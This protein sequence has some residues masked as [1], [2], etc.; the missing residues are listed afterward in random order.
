LSYIKIIIEV[1]KRRIP[2]SFGDKDDEPLVLGQR[3]A[4]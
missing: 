4:K 2:S 1:E 3:A